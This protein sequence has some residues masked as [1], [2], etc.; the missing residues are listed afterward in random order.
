MAIKIVFHG[1]LKGLVSIPLIDNGTIIH[2]SDRNASV[3]DMIEALGVPHT[4]IGRIEANGEEVSFSYQVKTKDRLD[5]YALDAPVDFSIPSLLRPEPLYEIRFLADVNVGRLAILLRMVGMDTAY[6]NGLS[7]A[8]LAE[9]SS[10][11]KRILL[12]RDTRLLK[13]SKVI[14]GHLVRETVP[15]RQL[16]EIVNLFNLTCRLSPFTRCLV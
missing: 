13:R 14:F 16:A 6:K 12:T 1:D 3:K 10:I 15:L 2:N 11:E 5:V 7:D 8:E 4:E 9:I